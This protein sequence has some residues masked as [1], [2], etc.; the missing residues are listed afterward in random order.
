MATWALLEDGKEI[1]VYRCAH[2]GA[3]RDDVENEA[4]ERGMAARLKGGVV[5]AFNVE[6]VC[7]D[8]D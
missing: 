5:T 6:I 4:I 2:S 3:C 1:V 7:Y 8:D